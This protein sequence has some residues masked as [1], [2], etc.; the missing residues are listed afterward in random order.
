MLTDDQMNLHERYKYLRLMQPEYQSANRAEQG[1]MLDTLETVT[2]LDRKTLIRLL[3]SDLKHQPRRRERGNTYGRD[4]DQALRVIAESYDYLC[5]ERLTPNLVGMAE[6]LAAHH[7]LGGL[8][9]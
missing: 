9:Q 2:G 5:A 3:S 6:H 4:V 1:R 8:S 7:E